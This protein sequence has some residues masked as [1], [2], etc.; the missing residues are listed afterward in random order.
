MALF[1][2]GRVVSHRLTRGRARDRPRRGAR[3]R[4][5]KPS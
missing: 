4:A 5:E 1:W 2:T 3:E